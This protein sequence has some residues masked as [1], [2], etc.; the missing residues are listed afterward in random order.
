MFGADPWLGNEFAEGPNFLHLALQRKVTRGALVPIFNIN[1]IA[2]PALHCSEWSFFASLFEGEVGEEMFE[3]IDKER[4]LLHGKGPRGETC[5]HIAIDSADVLAV[6]ILIDE[7]ADRTATD[8]SGYTPL[9]YANMVLKRRK[10]TVKGVRRS[11]ECA[12]L[13]LL[14]Y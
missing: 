9:E 5:L 10:A 1:L 3:R 13:R 12:S 4:K 11:S 14:E 6:G 8:A 2:L 7:G